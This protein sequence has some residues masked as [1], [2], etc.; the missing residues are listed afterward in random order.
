MLKTI[1]NWT[2]LMR[3]D[4]FSLES[5]DQFR[6]HTRVIQSI[7]SVSR[8]EDID[9]PASLLASPVRAHDLDPDLGINC[10]GLSA[11]L[12]VYLFALRSGH[13]RYQIVVKLDTDPEIK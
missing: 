6:D 5:F 4:A 1:G 11:D 12:L 13:T 7:R 10:H 8:D 3:N 2:Y 9:V